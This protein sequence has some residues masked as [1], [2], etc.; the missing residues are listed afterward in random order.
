MT[1]VLVHGVPETARLWTSLRSHLQRPDVVTVSLP[2]FGN[3]RPEGFDATMDEYAAWL[4][5][6]V[7]S[8]DGPIDLVGH[9]WGAGFTM[10]LVSLRPDLVRSWVMDAAGL[11]DPA[12]EWHDFAKIWQTPGDG[13]AFWER[14]LGLSAAEKTGVFLALGVPEDDATAM[15]EAIDATMAG[16]ILDLYRSATKIHEEWGP[17]FVDIPKPGLV[18]IP[19]EDPFL[20]AEMA[21]RA[22]KR[23]GARTAR[24]EGVGHWWMAQDPAAAARLLESFWAEA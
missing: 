1:A 7:E 6:H 12:F 13:E 8:L 15:A 24:L 5:G 14:Q 19:T 2:G 18:V 23:A 4:I 11:A 16:C 20:H 10:R 21:T 3:P 22:A 17:D 9:D